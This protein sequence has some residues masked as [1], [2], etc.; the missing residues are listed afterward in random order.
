MYVW[1]RSNWH[2]RT[3]R[4]W[5][6]Y[7]RYISVMM[8]VGPTIS[9]DINPYTLMKNL[10]TFRRNILSSS[11]YVNGKPYK[12]VTFSLLCT[13]YHSSLKMVAIFPTWNVFLILHFHFNPEHR[14]STFPRNNDKYLPG[15][16]ES[17][18]AERIGGNALDPCSR[19]ACFDSRPETW[20]TWLLVFLSDSREM[21]G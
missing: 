10:L 19:Y 4:V 9:W 18:L 15:Y 12:Q 16:T 7:N 8:G 2:C 3:M 11:L 6:L 14:N 13:A 17:Y 5:I 1:R 20:L 21:P